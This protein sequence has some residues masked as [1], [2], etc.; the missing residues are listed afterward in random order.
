MTDGVDVLPTL[1][2]G[3][4]GTTLPDWVRRRLR[5]GLGGVCLFARN[6]ADHAQ[7]AA[8]NAE[9]LDANPRAVIALDEEGGD[10]TR[11]FAD[12]GSPYPGN[13]VLGRLDDLE[14]TEAVGAD[15]GWALRR[16]GCTLTFAP[17]VD[18]ND[19]PDNPVIGVRSFGAEADLV[20]RHGAAWTRGVQSTGI[21][22][23]AKHFPGHGDTATD[24]HLALPVVDRSP[25]ELRARELVPFTAAVE[26]GTVAVMTSHLLFPQVDPAAAATFSRA[27]STGLLREELGFTGVLVTDALDMAGATHP[28]G[29]PESAVRALAA[30]CDLL[31]LGNDNTDEQVE[32]IVRAVRAAVADG[33]LPAGRVP[34]AAGRVHAMAD[35]LTASRAAH[36]VPEVVPALPLDDVDL[37]GTFDHG[38][39]A[40]DWRRRA[41][42]GFTVVRLEDRPN[43][44]VGVVPW[45]PD[46]ADHGEVV[47]HPGD[48]LDLDVLGTRPV[49][50]LGRDV[51][52]HPEARATVDRLRT[53]HDVLV[54]D[55]GWPSPDRAYADVA[56]FGASR[57][58]GRAL[59][60]WIDAG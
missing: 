22:A 7:L 29:T 34:E 11:L 14:L 48:A 52:R 12:V 58:V 15:V 35:A 30:G 4:T 39:R 27:I 6:I 51:H 19:D 56:T 32:A 44:A 53:T 21:G 50:V 16:T 55:L 10:V 3:F 9:I 40:I 41:T 45:G 57:R 49:L 26:A 2:P 20:A 46:L 54:V 25:D 8:L 1:L 17:D 23:T 47:V 28:G 59:L 5:G 36:P 60:S 42:D 37:A 31:C 43:I 38:R 24:S 13:A 18:V 33:S